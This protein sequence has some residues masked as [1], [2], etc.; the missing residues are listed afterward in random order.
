MLNVIFHLVRETHLTKAK[1]FNV[2]NHVS[3]GLGEA[4]LYLRMSLSLLFFLFVC[5]LKRVCA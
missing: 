1:Q 4:N 5:F 2:F 3:E